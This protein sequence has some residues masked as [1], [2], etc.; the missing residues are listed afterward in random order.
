VPATVCSELMAF[1]K[2]GVRLVL[3]ILGRDGNEY[4]TVKAEAEVK[5]IIKEFF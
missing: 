5:V 4:A 2:D 3:V 1:K